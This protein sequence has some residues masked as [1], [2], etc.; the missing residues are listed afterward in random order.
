MARS[1][2]KLIF[3][4]GAPLSQSLLWDDEFLS[5]SL[6]DPFLDSSRSSQCK[7]A[8]STN[9]GPTWRCLSVENNGIHAGLTSPTSANHPDDES[10]RGDDRALFLNASHL[11]Q[12]SAGSLTDLSQSEHSSQF[13]LEP[14][15]EISQFYEESF[16]I[17]EQV[18]SS[19]VTGHDASNDT[20]DDESFNDTLNS[21]DVHHSPWDAKASMVKARL[22]A[23]LPR[24]L[25]NLPT[26]AYLQSI[27]P[28]TVTIN[29]VVGIISILPPRQINTRRGGRRKVNL[30]EM[31]VGD[32]T[33]AGFAMN[34]WLD[35]VPN[36]D[37]FAAAGIAAAAA[38][39]TTNTSETQSLAATVT[40]LRPRDI[41]LIRN[42]AL[43]SF[44]GKVYG[45]SLQRKGM[46]TIDLLHRSTVASTDSTDTYGAYSAP[47]LREI[48]SSSSEETSPLTKLK[49]VRQWVI[50]FVSTTTHHISPDR[51]LKLH[52]G[53]DG[54]GGCDN[55]SKKR[56]LQLQ[57]HE[58]SAH[59]IPLP[60][61]TQ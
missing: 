58:A 39:T 21:V 5:A 54:G 9:T 4:A 51:R 56:K 40:S 57:Q 25:N 14:E 22:M 12:V 17:H 19:D 26:A 41:I 32:E 42:A 52:D 61:D 38:A 11:S 37:R 53:D 47:E 50:E 3:L 46:T 36:I 24:N 2:G 31:M 15:E 43:N 44:Q 59:L 30:V 20:L 45:Q 35:D 27:T 8:T 48:S 55:Q 10:D 6:Q 33:R 60:T 1:G 34:I 49:K 7:P 28:Q 16:A 13:N 18:S 23:S 29:V